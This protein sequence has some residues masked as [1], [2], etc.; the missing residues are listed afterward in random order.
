[1]LIYGG[2]WAIDEVF[3]CV[4]LVDDVESWDEG[5]FKVFLF[6]I[7]VE[8][9]SFSSYNLLVGLVFD[10]GFNL[11]SVGFWIPTLLTYYF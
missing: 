4:N 2:N 9:R 6:L 8:G 1:M 7:V 10:G 11:L 5:G 3:L